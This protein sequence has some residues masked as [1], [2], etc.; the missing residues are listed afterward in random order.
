MADLQIT[1]RFRS[2]WSADA[3]QN[4]DIFAHMSCNGPNVHRLMR[5][6][7]KNACNTNDLVGQ[8]CTLQGAFVHPS[9]IPKIE[10]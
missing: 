6:C 10:G 3:H 8:C 1:F 9:M 5:L 7:T 4:A 2:G